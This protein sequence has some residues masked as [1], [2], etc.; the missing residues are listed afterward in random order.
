MDRSTVCIVLSLSLTRMLEP[1]RSG[2]QW[3]NQG[4]QKTARVEGTSCFLLAERIDRWWCVDKAEATDSARP[5]QARW[6][7]GVN[8]GYNENCSPFSR[9]QRPPEL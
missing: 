2:G 1:T 6:M 7:A 3:V 5:Q 4:N 8:A 9:S